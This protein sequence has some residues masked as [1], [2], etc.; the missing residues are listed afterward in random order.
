MKWLTPTQ[1][2]APS[3]AM[4]TWKASRL[5]RPAWQYPGTVMALLDHL[6]RVSTIAVLA[7]L[8]VVLL[9]DL[10]RSVAAWTGSGFFITIAS[11][12]W[13]SSPDYVAW[14]GLDLLLQGFALAAP[15]AFWLFSRALFQDDEAISGRDSALLVA[16]VAIGFARP[17]TRV[18]DLAYYGASL[19]LVGVALSMV[20]RGFPADLIEPRRRLRTAFTV[21]IGVEIATVLGAEILLAGERA[22]RLLELV[23]SLAALALTTLFGAWLV[24]P[25]RDLLADTSA[26]QAERVPAAANHAQAEDDRIRAR[27]LTLMTAE[28][29]YRREGLTIG[30]LAHTLDIPE[31]RLRR[32]INQQLGHRNFNAFLN[33]LRTAEACRMLADPVNQ[34][35]PIFNLALDLG[36]GSVGP[37]NRAFRATTGLS[38][39]EYR[40]SRLSGP[41]AAPTTPAES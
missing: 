14:P 6:A 12:L 16:L 28:Q 30:A 3:R 31:Y 10:P 18:A 9:R 19:G 1:R 27:L 11:Y 13:L 5:R 23:K 15:A 39:T 25:R 7:L 8:A 24:T 20:V 17:V 38:P 29:L 22:P 40:R 2:L 36:Y 4:P 34:R 35:L 37:F 26:P 21:V 33:E 32:V 41:A